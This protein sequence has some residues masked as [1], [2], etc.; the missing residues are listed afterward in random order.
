MYIALKVC[1]E[2]TAAV[3]NLTWYVII[4]LKLCHKTQL[5]RIS[6]M[7]H[8]YRL[9]IVSQNAAFQNLIH[10]VHVYCFKI[11]LQNTAF[12]NPLYYG[13]SLLLASNN[14]S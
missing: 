13:T 2:Y 9:K 1:H 11:A 3:H 5:F 14:M 8:D 6:Y 4:A 12:Q 10:M 7:I